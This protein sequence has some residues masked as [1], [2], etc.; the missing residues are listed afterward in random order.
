MNEISQV[1]LPSK[2][3]TSQVNLPSNDETSQVNIP[4]ELQ[5]RISNL[6][7]KVSLDE[8]R[9]IIVELCKIQPRTRKELADILNKSEEYLRKQILPG[10]LENELSLLYP[11][12][13]NT[14][15]QA[16]KVK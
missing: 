1:N 2:N 15:N 13:P 11:D 12:S 8:L 7:K 9:L 4:E 6:G 3:E 10:M 14:P 5:M 16:Y